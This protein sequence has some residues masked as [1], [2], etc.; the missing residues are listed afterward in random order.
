VDQAVDQATHSSF[1]RRPP[2]DE[3]FDT[4]FDAAALAVSKLST[5]A[6]G[7][8]VTPLADPVAGCASHAP[9]QPKELLIGSLRAAITKIE[10][11]EL[12][13]GGNR[14]PAEAAWQLGCPVVDRL[15]PQGLDAGGVHEVKAAARIGP[16]GN[17]ASAGDWM[18]GLGFAL[19]LAVRR[20]M[21]ARENKQD[22]PWMLWCWPRALAGEFGAP[23]AR[24]LAE[25]GLD[26]SRLLI[27][28]TGGAS[29]ALVALEDG[30]KSSSLSLAFGIFDEIALTPAR[31]LSLAAATTAT[32][33]LL[34]THPA[35]PASGA[36]ATR[37]RVGRMQSAP[38]AYDASREATCKGSRA[39]GNVRFRVGLERCRASPQSAQRG[40]AL[41][42]WC[43]ETRTFS[44]ASRLAGH[45]P[46]AGRAHGR[47]A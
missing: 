16:Y 23:S 44:L 24:G 46:Q 36:T 28:E 41:V 31:R 17:S 29:D 9:P 18:T 22:A 43:D 47:S 15:L 25:L 42:E 14:E 39:P 37:W 7:P 11:H 35:S 34:I 3:A 20:S 8:A 45:A 26:P 40:M 4:D 12:C 21:M 13:G 2:A 32:P 1:S 6:T 5:P 27:V 10:G 38:H 19:R 30:L 33:C